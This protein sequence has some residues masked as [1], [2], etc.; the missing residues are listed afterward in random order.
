MTYTYPT[1]PLVFFNENEIPFAIP[2]VMST[3]CS[4]IINHVISN[5][6]YTSSEIVEIFLSTT[7]VSLS[8]HVISLAFRHE[9]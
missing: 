6:V 3:L 9:R 4:L 8:E 1:K 5:E 2:P 7:D